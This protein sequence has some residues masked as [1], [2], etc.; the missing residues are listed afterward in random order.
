MLP[1]ESIVCRLVSNRFQQKFS[2]PWGV[3]TIPT[4]LFE[5]LLSQGQAG[6]GD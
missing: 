3:T 6:F 2:S 4:Q 5:Q 1:L